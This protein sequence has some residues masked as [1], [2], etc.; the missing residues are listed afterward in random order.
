[1]VLVVDDERDIAELLAYVL[2]KEG[3][4]VHCASSAQAALLVLTQLPVEL[5]LTDYMMPVLDGAELLRTMRATPETAHIPV[6]VLSAL[7][8]ETV[9]ARCP[10]MDDFLQKPFKVANL[11]VL[12]RKLLEGSAGEDSNA[13]MASSA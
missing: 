10:D 5:V 11:L 3:H 2:A 9:R 8:E 13:D 6:L 7:S 4:V 12:V 1:V